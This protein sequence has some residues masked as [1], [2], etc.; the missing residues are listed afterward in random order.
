MQLRRLRSRSVAL[1]GILSSECTSSMYTRERSRGQGHR[2]KGIR[3][4]GQRSSTLTGLNLH[5]RGGLVTRACGSASHHQW[6][7]P[8]PVPAPGVGYSNSRQSPIRY[9]MYDPSITV[10]VLYRA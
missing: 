8:V 9:M 1:D 6:P 7:V 4:V 5:V 10:R 3:S 2:C